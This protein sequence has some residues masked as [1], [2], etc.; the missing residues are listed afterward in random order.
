[1]K[2]PP[3]LFNRYDIF[4]IIESQKKALSKAVAGASEPASGTP[5]DDVVNRL[6]AQFTVRVPQLHPDQ[7]SVEQEEVDVDISGDP[8]RYFSD[9]SRPLYVKGTQLSVHVPF[10]GEEL[11]FDTRPSSFTL[12]PPRGEVQGT[13]LIL[14][15][16]YPN[17][18]PPPNLKGQM[19]SDLASINRYLEN[20]RSSAN[21]LDSELVPIARAAWQKRKAE[22][23]IRAS[24]IADLGLPERRL[25]AQRQAPPSPTPGIATAV[26]T[27]T[28][29]SNKWNVFISHATEDKA[30]IAKP[31][32]DALV[33][34]GLE[35]WYDEYALTVGDSLRQKIDEGLAKSE[36][37][38]VILSEAFFS[39]H[40][41]RQE[42]NGLAAR[43]N[44]GGKV[45]L[46]VWHNISRNDV[47]EYSP[48]LADKLGVPTSMGLEHVV[49]ALLSAMR[50]V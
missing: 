22:F 7:M 36:F 25:E 33:A 26:K 45:I 5:D 3:L 44:G 40:W 38:I 15:Y 34:A 46:P 43:E 18:S 37:G 19:D 42:L 11:L 27:P 10:T 17:D 50:K 39:K 20:L 49:A 21:T 29:A 14:T 12:S 9:P 32:A 47:L 48:P 1:M 23:S 31:L 6:V 4:G 2:I 28:K 13:E 35:V 41:P 24:I 16:T 8:R 30:A